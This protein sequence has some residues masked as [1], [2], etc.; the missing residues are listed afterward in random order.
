M[1]LAVN[2]GLGVDNQ[3]FAIRKQDKCRATAR[4]RCD[5]YSLNAKGR[6]QLAGGVEACQHSLERLAPPGGFK[7]RTY[8]DVAVG[9][10]QSDKPYS[11]CPVAQTR[12]REA[13]A[14][15]RGIRGSVGIQTLN[16]QFKPTGAPVRDHP[17]Y[18]NL[19]VRL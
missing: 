4:R 1:P 15:K 2:C 18:H 13:A 16:P 17:G 9:L 19:P 14:T 6:V 12:E 3:N 7:L 11:S 10:D 5:C 8:Q